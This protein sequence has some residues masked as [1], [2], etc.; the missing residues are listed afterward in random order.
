[1]PVK[2]V[3]YPYTKPRGLMESMDNSGSV[4]METKRKFQSE[5]VFVWGDSS[6]HSKNKNSFKSSTTAGSS[7]HRKKLCAAS[8]SSWSSQSARTDQDYSSYICSSFVLPPPPPRKCVACASSSQWIECPVVGAKAKSAGKG[9]SASF[10]SIQSFEEAKAMQR[11]VEMYSVNEHNF[12][13][14]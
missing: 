11:E 14:G 6:G 4:E 13:S 3:H 12:G 5:S 10:T 2:W 1:M 9:V 7:G 8:H